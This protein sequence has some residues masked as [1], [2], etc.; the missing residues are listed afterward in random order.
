MAV[1]RLVYF[2]APGGR[3][4]RTKATSLT[5]IFVWLD[6]IV[7]IV[8]AGGGTMLSNDNGANIIK[9]GMNIY[10]AGVGVQLGIV[11]IFSAMVMCF[12]QKIRKVEQDGMRRLRFSIWI[13]MAVLAL[14]VVSCPLLCQAQ[15]ILF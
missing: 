9:I 4:W 8:Q 15:R 6:I 7:F 11:I 2:Q 13:V 10:M 5:V 1:S 12:Y 14:I 3:I